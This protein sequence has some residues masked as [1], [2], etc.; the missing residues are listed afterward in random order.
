MIT[1]LDSVL[2][3]DLDGTLLKSDLFYET[4][5]SALG[6]NLLAP[7]HAIP[8]LMRGK[9]V[10]KSYLATQA[11]IDPALLPYDD[12]VIA[13][14]QDHKGRGGR[15]VLATASNV[16]LAHSI[17]RHLGLFD[18]V[19]A[20][21]ETRN[22][23][24]LTKADYLVARF[25]FG[26]FTYAGDAA[27][28]L[29]VWKVSRQIITVNA[30]RAVR[31]KAECFGKPVEH[32]ITRTEGAGPYLAALRP[33]Q[34]LKNLLVF[35]PLLAS[36]GF[37]TPTLVYSLLAFVAFCLT[38]SSVYVVNDLMDLAADRQHPRKR[39][40]PLASGALA[41]SQGSFLAIALFALGMAVSGCLGWTFLVAIV[42]YYLLSTAYSLSLKR[43]AILDICVLAGLYTLRIVAGAIASEIMLSVWLLAFAIFFFFS[44][45]ALK[46]QAEL[47]DMARR[48]VLTNMGRGYHLNDLP[49]ISAVA[50]ASGYM[51]VLVMAL[52][53]NS[54]SV[55][56]L[57]NY[58][59]ALWGICAVLLYWLTRMVLV[60]HR[61]EMHDD[62]VLFAV[63]D[64]VSQGALVAV[65][66]FAVLG[67]VL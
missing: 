53:V 2:V 32:L 42:V 34:W 40:R 38:A 47:V 19:H 50:L 22:L 43:R 58:P 48:K 44:L 66:G 3:V 13:F 27:A 51:S 28:D 57:Y 23:K 16:T 17:A 14:V 25:G 21:D 9:S 33:H 56:E 35:L 20:S 36:H 26:G 60:T 6:Q 62:P 37:E 46:R 1:D 67:A 15:T 39:F 11:H 4:L 52:Y 55:V 63:H 64:R 24:G 59:P 29:P 12:A 30:T 45:A 7:F 49:I 8:S 18:E 65:L 41:L 5:W 10:F 54:P 61:G 31:A